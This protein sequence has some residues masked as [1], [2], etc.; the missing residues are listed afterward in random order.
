MAVKSTHVSASGPITSSGV[1]CKVL[2][3]MGLGGASAGSV[4]LKDGG[5][6]GTAK[7]TIDAPA[8]GFFSTKIPGGGRNYSTDCYATLNSTAPVGVTVFYE[9]FT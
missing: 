2:A 3:V 4:T 5:S 1:P 6:G 9:D 8:N 7:D